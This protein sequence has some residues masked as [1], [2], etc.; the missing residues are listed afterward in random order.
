MN[1]YNKK[2][3]VQIKF[4][5]TITVRPMSVDGNDIKTV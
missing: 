5:Y 3:K 1:V 2:F 4:R